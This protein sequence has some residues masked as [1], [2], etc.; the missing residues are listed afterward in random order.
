M[1]TRGTAFGRRVPAVN[2]D[3]VP[4]IPFCLVFELGH[5][6]TPSDIADSFAEFG[7]L[8][9]VLDCKALNTDR[10]VFTDQMSRKFLQEITAAIS[11]LGMDTSHFLGSFG[12]VFRPFLLFCVPPLSRSKL[13]LIFGEEVGISYFL[14]SRE[15]D[16]V[17]Q[18]KINPN[19]LLDGFKLGN[20]LL[21]QDG[22][23]VTISSVFGDGDGA[24]FAPVGQGTRP[25][26]LKRFSH[27]CEGK[28]LGIPMKGCTR[29]GSTLLVPFLFERW[30]LATS[31]KEVEKRSIQMA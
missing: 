21:Y 5:K 30:I 31:F 10:L 9:Q 17:L 26:D 27:F 7:I 19:S 25:D 13:L 18:S 14:T 20:I 12:T 2:F 6:L 8:D 22:D 1:S 3:Q 29:I 11:Y 16:N 4:A 15:D 24:R 23:E 28:C